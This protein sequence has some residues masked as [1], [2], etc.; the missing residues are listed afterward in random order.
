M[1]NSL[2]SIFSDKIDK[3]TYKLYKIEKKIRN[4]EELARQRWEDIYDHHSHS[5]D[6]DDIK[7]KT[8]DDYYEH[9]ISTPRY[10]RLMNEK[11]LIESELNFCH[12]QINQIN[13][14]TLD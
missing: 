11:M 5:R 10:N 6:Y 7:Y 4:M 1:D 13:N 3:L 8:M 14:M 2:T 12:N 9:V